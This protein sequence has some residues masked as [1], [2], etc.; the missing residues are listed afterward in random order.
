[1]NLAVRVDTPYSLELTACS[2]VSRTTVSR[3]A[4]AKPSVSAGG[5]SSRPCK[6]TRAAALQDRFFFL[7]A[8]CK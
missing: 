8:V 7:L 2:I 3:I 1:M 6:H 5:E 4:L